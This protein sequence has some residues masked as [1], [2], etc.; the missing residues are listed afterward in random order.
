MR[1]ICI[2]KRRTT[3][4]TVVQTCKLMQ[5]LQRSGADGVQANYT[6]DC[7]VIQYFLLYEALRIVKKY[8]A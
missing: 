3:E 7:T 1:S 2:V 4:E 5:G 8:L 6:E